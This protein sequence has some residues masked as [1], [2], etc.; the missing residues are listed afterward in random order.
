MNAI[1]CTTTCPIVVKKE[2]RKR[3]LQVLLRQQKKV[4]HSLSLLSGY[5]TTESTYAWKT[6][7]ALEKT[8]SDANNELNDIKKTDLLFNLE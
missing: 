1:V 5:N 6:V 3:A 8:I 7:R 2:S 4:A